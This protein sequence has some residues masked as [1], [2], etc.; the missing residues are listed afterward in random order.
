MRKGGQL[1]ALFRWISLHFCPLKAHLVSTTS[2]RRGHLNLVSKLALAGALA[3]TAA[4]GSAEDQI[5]E[6][7]VPGPEQDPYIWLEE[8]RSE[9]ALAWARRK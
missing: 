9:E 4:T 5:D 8:A 7:G 3:M 2:P 6:T 1:V